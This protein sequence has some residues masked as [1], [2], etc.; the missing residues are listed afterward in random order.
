MGS[1]PPIDIIPKL[2][3][4]MKC[5]Y[6]NPDDPK[7]FYSYALIQVVYNASVDE[8]YSNSNARYGLPIKD[9]KRAGLFARHWTSAYSTEYIAYKYITTMIGPSANTVKGTNRLRTDIARDKL[10]RQ[11]QATMVAYIPV[12]LPTI[13]ERFMWIDLTFPVRGIL[14]PFVYQKDKR[15]P[16]YCQYLQYDFRRLRATVATLTRMSW[17]AEKPAKTEAGDADIVDEPGLPPAYVEDLKAKGRVP[18]TFKKG[19]MELQIN[20]VH[21]WWQPEW[22]ARLDIARLYYTE[23][24]PTAELKDDYKTWYNAVCLFKYD[25]VQASNMV[26]KTFGSDE[27]TLD[28]PVRDANMAASHEVIDLAKLLSDENGTSFDYKRNSDADGDLAAKLVEGFATFTTGMIPIVGPLAT[29]GWTAMVS[30]IKDPK[31]FVE[32]NFGPQKS[33]E[34]LVTLLSTVKNITPAFKQVPTPNST[35]AAAPP[36]VTLKDGQRRSPTQPVIQY[37]GDGGNPFYAYPPNT[38]T[39]RQLT[40]FTSQAGSSPTIIKAISF[41]W[42]GFEAQAEAPQTSSAGERL[43]SGMFDAIEETLGIQE[44]TKPAEEVYGAHWDVAR[45]LP[46]Q[47]FTFEPGEMVNWLTIR[48]AGRVDRIEFETNNGRHFVAGGTGGT[49]YKLG[50]GFII[51]AEGRAAGDLDKLGLAIS[52]I[53]FYQGEEY[54]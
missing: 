9:H 7:D 6:Y 51:G 49:E 47:T 10:E 27:W 46:S 18:A 1:H 21:G 5:S 4:L 42:Y 17:E 3:K 23:V 37:G 38:T 50:S 24:I 15:D 25:N 41:A 43:V 20:Q 31:K 32:D 40:V 16:G 39:L 22:T 29:W 36:K 34:L 8:F 11:G 54:M 44:N 19:Q 33:G 14:L 28:A 30:A 45:F 13:E 26:Q 48:A 12:L 35:M 2:R 53:D 52:D